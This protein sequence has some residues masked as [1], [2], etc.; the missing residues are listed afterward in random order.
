M[1]RPDSNGASP[2]RFDLRGHSFVLLYDFMGQKLGLKGSDLAVYAR[3][4]GF[5][6]VEK[7][8]YES[9]KGTAAFFG[10]STRAVFET[11]GRLK[12]K[13]LIEEVPPCGEAMRI[14]SKCYQPAHGPLA[15]A[16][17]MPLS[18]EEPTYAE[19]SP[20]EESSGNQQD[21]HEESSCPPD[22]MPEESSC[23]DM[24]NSHPIPKRNNSY[25]E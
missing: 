20:H 6:Q 25:F 17:I 24:K 23:P 15:V 5:H 21:T 3:I 12:E 14:G 13:G 22:Q 2:H 16:G 8:F 4:F 7:P 18:S 19:G 10:I 11:V 1:G 9:K